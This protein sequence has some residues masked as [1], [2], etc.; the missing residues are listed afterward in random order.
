MKKVYFYL[1][2][3][4]ILFNSIIYLDNACFQSNSRAR[5]AYEYLNETEYICKNM[6]NMDFPFLCIHS[7]E[8]DFVDIHGPLLLQDQSKVIY[9][10]YFYKNLYES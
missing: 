5:V 8:D 6:A 3:N 9:Y 4:R 1:N 7:K 10:T 2:T